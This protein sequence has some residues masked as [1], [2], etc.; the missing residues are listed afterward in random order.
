MAF[1]ILSNTVETTFAATQE[2]DRAL[3]VFGGVGLE[4]ILGNCHLLH[5]ES[6]G[7][8]A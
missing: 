8:A 1:K 4:D 6:P 3:R 5:V 7:G 2:P